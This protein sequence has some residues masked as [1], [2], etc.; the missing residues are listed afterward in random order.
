MTAITPENDA[1]TSELDLRDVPGQGAV[2]SWQP[3]SVVGEILAW[4]TFLGLPLHCQYYLVR[5]HENDS[6]R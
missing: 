5:T 2:N 3:A 1:P 6:W 4:P